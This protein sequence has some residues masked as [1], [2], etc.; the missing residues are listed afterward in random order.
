MSPTPEN[1]PSVDRAN[2]PVFVLGSPR[3]GTTILAR[4][5]AT[6]PGFWTGDES[7]VLV[8]LFGNG[9]LERNYLRQPRLDGSW[10]CKQ[11]I[12][13]KE[14]LGFLG[15]G[16]NALFSKCS[17]GKR[18]IDHTP[19]YTLMASDLADLFPQ[20]LFVHILRDGRSVISSMVNY[21]SH[22]PIEQRS[23]PEARS[24]GSW[25]GNFAEA[26]A[27]WRTFVRSA[28][29]FCQQHPDRSL[30]VKYERLI[31]APQVTFTEIF[32]FL[33]AKPHEGAVDFLRCNRLNSSFRAESGNASSP[34]QARWAGWTLEERKCF[35]AEASELMEECGYAPRDRLWA[36]A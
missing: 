5:L 36:E 30:T 17:D 34:Q 2:S 10:L 22:M 12:S 11:G 18:W 7:Q 23:T 4:S 1:A 15:I 14:F 28:L 9:E 24:I 35:V 33:S 26:C 32:N 21:L 3:S 20:A 16:I 8:D 13:R 6:H 27:T 31:T 25:A 29:S 19:T